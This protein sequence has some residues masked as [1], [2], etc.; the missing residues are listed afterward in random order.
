MASIIKET[1]T[2]ASFLNLGNIVNSINKFKKISKI[3]HLTVYIFKVNVPLKD[4]NFF[5]TSH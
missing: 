1:H 2:I 4:S 3:T 5:L